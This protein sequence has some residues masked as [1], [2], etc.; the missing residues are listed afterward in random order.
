MPWFG[1][2]MSPASM[3]TARF[4]ETWA[5]A[6]DVHDAL[7]LEAEPTDRIRHVAHIGVRTRGF[8]FANR[9]LDVAAPPTC[10][11]S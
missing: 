3:V 6:L 5:H 1:P 7:G 9:G 11:S 8:S 4:M 10:A 2:P